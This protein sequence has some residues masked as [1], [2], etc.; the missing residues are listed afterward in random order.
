ME[1]VYLWVEDYKN[2]KKQGFNFSPRFRCYY[3]KEKNELTINENKG[4]V[5]IFPDNINITAIVG[6]NGTGKTSILERILDFFIESSDS[7]IIFAIGE[8]LYC[9]YNNYNFNGE[10]EIIGKSIILGRT[11]EYLSVITNTSDFQNKEFFLNRE[12]SIYE[13]LHPMSVKENHFELINYSLKL[14]YFDLS[15]FESALVFCSIINNK[16][17][18]F[19][20]IEYKIELNGKYLK[21]RLFDI[22]LYN[23]LL[24]S[25]R[26]AKI[27]EMAENY[28]T[29]ILQEKDIK[30]IISFY[31]FLTK[32]KEASSFE[33]H[34]F[35]QSVVTNVLID[36]DYNL[37]YDTF[38][39]LFNDIY[40]KD[41]FSS[42]S[43][44]K[45]NLIDLSKCENF[46]KLIGKLFLVELREENR[47]YSDLSYGEKNSLVQEGLFYKNIMSSDKND[48][49][50][51]LDEN[52]ISFHPNWQKQNFNNMII[53]LRQFKNKKIHLVI[54]THS[55]FLLSDIPKLN[56]IFLEKDEKTGNSINVTD[57]MKDFNTFGANIHTL[58]S[59]GFFMKDG[60][61]GEFVKKTIQDVIDYLDDKP[62]QNM[63]KQKAWQIIQL[64]GEPFLKYKLEEKYNEKFLTEEEKKQ[65]KIKQLED[66]LKR[67][68]DDNTQS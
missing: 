63:N 5:S 41:I 9:N 50:I 39:D 22:L 6:E 66:E 19:N 42:I 13:N 43:E 17:L 21:Y 27:E 12:L 28:I 25:I 29:R 3:D 47:M 62:T 2:I 4:Y 53:Y 34:D 38:I 67:L 57:K 16:S 56:V 68:K 35:V 15:R 49:L 24:S 1:L 7:I 31:L 61:M 51:L 46:N 37:Y 59:H 18:I 11:N 14:S 10:I 58:L 36:M 55:P 60:V 65:N 30:Y 64:V 32:H 8:K 48:I 23:P 54:T 20:P 26:D 45:N 44:N 52:N 40:K 33:Y